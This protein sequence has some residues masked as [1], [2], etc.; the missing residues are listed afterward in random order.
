M[1]SAQTRSWRIEF[2]R[3]AARRREQDRFLREADERR[4][5]KNES[6][7][8]DEDFF[9]FAVSAML[10][11]AD[12]IEQLHAALDRYDA[13]TVEA[14]MENQKAL[15]ASRGRIE[16][17]LGRAYVLPDGR[18][19]FKTA[20]G[21]RV[22]DEHGTELGADDIDPDA[23]E[24]WRPRYEQFAEEV[25]QEQA[26]KTEREKLIEFQERIEAARQHLQS[27]EDLTKADLAD[28]EAGLDASMPLAV[29]RK[30][31]GFEEAPAL[32]P[33]RDFGAAAGLAP[34]LAD[35][36]LDM[37]EFGR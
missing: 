18:R 15:D 10:A 28:I 21:L 35:L 7:R 3:S 6:G 14:L 29:A 11:S 24:D 8:L 17:M 37:P 5:D 22:F 27:D 16:S 25:A 23:I 31:P 12:D 9:E 13:L 34:H 19:V 2:A 33:A 4:K 1:D 32:D 26:L 36:K 30:L 20:D